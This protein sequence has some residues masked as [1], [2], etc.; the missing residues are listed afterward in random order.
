MPNIEVAI[1]PRDFHK[2]PL[3]CWDLLRGDMYDKE[4]DSDSDLC[5]CVCV[6]VRGLYVES[7]EAC[8]NR[9]YTSSVPSPNCSCI[10]RRTRSS[11]T[12]RC[13]SR[14]RAVSTARIARTSTNADGEQ[15]KGPINARGVSRNRT[16]TSGT[17][18]CTTS[19]R[20]VATANAWGG[21][22]VS[23]HE[24][25]RAQRGTVLASSKSNP[26]TPHVPPGAAPPLLI[27]IPSP[28]TAPLIGPC[29]HN[30]PN[31]SP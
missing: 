27:P 21:H 10:P 24:G 15:P 1:E 9:C 2:R 22:R 25:Y 5:L 28:R 3:L 4:S 31:P 17:S 11:T 23:L 12:S 20:T 14:S 8:I 30:T 19:D 7:K 13:S 18:T 29:R 6:W 26:L 16:G